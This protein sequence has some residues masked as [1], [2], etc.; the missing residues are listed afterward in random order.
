[1]KRPVLVAA[2]VALVVLSAFSVLLATRHPVQGASAVPSP[3]LGH[4]A[5]AINGTL[6][7]QST[8]PATSVAV[9]PGANVLTG[10]RGKTVVVNFWSSWCGPCKAEA[11]ELSTFAWDERQQPVVVLGVLFNDNVSAATSFANHYGSLYNSIVDAGGVDANRYGVTSPP[12]TYVI[13][14]RGQVAAELVG[15]TSVAQL[16]AVVQRVSQ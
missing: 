15:P 11:P 1:M 3:L 12:T 5:P 9:T 13:S 14:P 16:R 8:T 4:E 6:L 10:L 2:L 7:A